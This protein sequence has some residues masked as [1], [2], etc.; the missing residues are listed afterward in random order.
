MGLFKYYSL[1]GFVLFGMSVNAQI[2]FDQQVI[3]SFG[4]FSTNLDESI[5][6]SYTAGETIT[7]TDS[8]SSFIFTQGF[9]QPLLGLIALSIEPASC[10]N[11]SDGAVFVLYPRPNHTYEWFREGQALAIGDSL[12]NIPAGNYHILIHDKT[13]GLVEKQD[14]IV[15]AELEE[16]CALGFYTGITPNADGSNDFWVIEGIDSLANQVQIFDR[17]GNLVWQTQSYNNQNN[18]W[19]GQAKNGQPLASG[20]YYYIIELYANQEIYKGWVQILE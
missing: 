6:L 10:K 12:V 8:T 13:S 14:L 19:K 2:S 3:G 4:G 15:P 9:Q 20:T 1:M 16:N 11:K 17:W 18:H 5:Q 7:T